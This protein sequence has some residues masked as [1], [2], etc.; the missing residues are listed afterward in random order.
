M[1]PPY[2]PA[3]DT[4]DTYYEDHGNIESYPLV[5]IHPIGGNILIW[6]HEIP[7]LLKKRV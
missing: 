3:A 2:F 4:I 5:L 1:P 6:L 7:L